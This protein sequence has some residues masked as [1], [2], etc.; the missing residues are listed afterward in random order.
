M[1]VL[2]DG[3]LTDN[4]GVTVN[5]KN[6][7]IIMTSNL[8]SSIIQ[9]KI[10]K[11]GGSL[12]DFEYEEIKEKLMDLMRQTIRPEF[13]NR[14]DDTIVFHPL[15]REHIRNII[16]IQLARVDKMLAHNNIKITVRDSAK[17]WLSTKGY[18]PIYGARP[19]K[20]V[21]QKELTN[22]LATILLS[23]NA[24]GAAEFEV[25]VNPEASGLLFTEVFNDVEAWAE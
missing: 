22:K 1:Q 2:D 18:D 11:T 10:E 20:R 25:K 16:D 5:F 14:V 21:I 3:R 15:G 13:L 8:G 4:K 12:S 19:L 9:S 24:D 6:T 23:R 17:E 7:I